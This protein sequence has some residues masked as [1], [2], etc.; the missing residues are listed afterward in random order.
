MVGKSKTPLTSDIHWRKW[1]MALY[2]CLKKVF[3]VRV[4]LMSP[5]QI[6]QTLRTEPFIKTFCLSQS[7]SYQGRPQLL[8]FQ[9]SFLLSWLS[10]YFLHRVTFIFNISWLSNRICTP[11]RRQ[12]FEK[13]DIMWELYG[14]HTRQCK[15]LISCYRQATL[16]RFFC[17]YQRL[18][19]TPSSHLASPLLSS[20]SLPPL[21]IF[22]ISMTDSG[23]Y[24]SQV[25]NLWWA[26]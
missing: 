23:N 2:S 9:K 24:L 3:T 16:N 26:V 1:T 15:M 5:L 7:Q 11:F 13:V 18:N 14:V 17:L 4:T 20:S 19:T 21:C 8:D 22:Q 12:P 6:C 10:F 25:L